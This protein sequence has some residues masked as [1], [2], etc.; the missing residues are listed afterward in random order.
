[1]MEIQSSRG[2][3]KPDQYDTIKLA[4]MKRKHKSKSKSFAAAKS[5]QINSPDTVASRNF[6]FNSQSGNRKRKRGHTAPISIVS[7]DFSKM[8]SR[9]MKQRFDSVTTP[10]KSAQH[11]QVASV[12]KTP[13]DGQDYD[14]QLRLEES[15]VKLIN[16]SI[17]LEDKIDF[18]LDLVDGEVEQKSNDQQALVSKQL[19][20]MSISTSS[21]SSQESD[22][23]MSQTRESLDDLQNSGYKF[24]GSA[25][26]SMAASSVVS[27]RRKPRIQTRRVGSEQ[28]LKQREQR[29]QLYERRMSAS[30][31]NDGYMSDDTDYKLRDMTP[32]ENRVHG[33]KQRR[34]SLTLESLNPSVM[35]SGTQQMVLNFFTPLDANTLQML[36]V[37]TSDKASA[38]NTLKTTATLKGMIKSWRRALMSTNDDSTLSRNATKK[39]TAEM[40][41]FIIG[42]SPPHLVRRL[43]RIS[44]SKL[45]NMPTTS[46]EIDAKYLKAS[47]S[48]VR[49]NRG[50]REQV[51]IMNMLQDLLLAQN[52]S[53]EEIQQMKRRATKMKPR[54]QRKQPMSLVQQIDSGVKGVNNGAHKAEKVKT[55]AF[56]MMLDEIPDDDQEHRK[57]RRNSADPVMANNS[58]NAVDDEDDEKPLGVL[59]Q[60]EL[61]Q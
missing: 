32:I 34:K 26:S 61:L 16:D 36:D 43:S 23:A 17:Q 48:Q 24:D 4:G 41:Q 38:S 39:S 15:V 50:L 29:K 42:Q 20:M 7:S 18:E 47:P 3:G 11:H 53:L 6:S 44:T 21:S 60:T 52:K 9:Q 55:D 19:S 57:P 37:A 30:A 28:R 51:L 5:Q 40:R 13:I 14:L 45:S 22:D 58:H 12:I 54:K 33:K 56:K 1:M 8:N 10:R 2:L 25:S 35:R 46:G 59:F 27:L 49:R 31:D